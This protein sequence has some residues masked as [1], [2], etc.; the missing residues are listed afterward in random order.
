MA[1]LVKRPSTALYPLPVVLVTCGSGDQANII[2]LAWVGTICS[3][4]PMVGIAIRPSRHSN[5]LIRR[6]EE[7]VVNVPTADLVAQADYCGQV[8][9]RDVDKWAACG[10][11][12]QPGS[13][14]ATPLIAQCPVNLECKLAQIVPLGAHDL[15]VG[16][17]VA[18]QLDEAIL[19]DRG[20]IDY[21]KA[22]PFAYLGG[23][24]REIGEL[25]GQYGDWREEPLE[26]RRFVSS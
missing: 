2:T 26:V 9:G 11:T 16:E 1:K 23:Q 6:T 19:D 18:V 15:F 12:P 14:V 10:F 21:A 5:G 22:R 20:R 13:A 7:F 4:P 8:S 25:L 3:D 17:I 24:Y